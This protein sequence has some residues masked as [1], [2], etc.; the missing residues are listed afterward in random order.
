MRVK[1]V[2]RFHFST[3]LKRTDT[4]LYVIVTVCHACKKVLSIGRSVGRREVCPSCGAD[5]HCCFNC[6]FYDPAVSKQCRETVA[7]LVTEKAKSNYCDY[8]VF[9]D[10]SGV[11]SNAEEARRVLDHLFRK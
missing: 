4:L 6:K 10:R 2:S 7:E 11:N 5:M 1:R 8:F 9:A 3:C